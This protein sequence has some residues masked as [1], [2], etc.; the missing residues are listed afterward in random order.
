MVL[1]APMLS[2]SAIAHYTIAGSNIVY[3]HERIPRPRG[4]PLSCPREPEQQPESADEH[5]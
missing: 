2:T 5:W 3:L 1:G 4:D